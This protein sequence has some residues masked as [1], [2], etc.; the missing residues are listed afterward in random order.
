M[1]TDRLRQL[2]TLLLAGGVVVALAAAYAAGANGRPSAHAVRESLAQ[3]V[4]P[5][6]AKGRTLGLAR[7]TIP[8]HTALALHRHPGTQIAYIQSGT[9]TYTVKTGSVP[10]YHGAG[11]DKPRLIR[12]VK[13]GHSGSVP[14]GDWVIERP[15]TIHF[16]ANNGSRPLVVLLATLFTDGRPPSIP[17]AG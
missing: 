16:G 4:N 9:L 2:G 13:A 10:V 1:Q 7:V 17:V 5:A 3:V 6:G 11:D 12:T 15:G 8:A 14:A